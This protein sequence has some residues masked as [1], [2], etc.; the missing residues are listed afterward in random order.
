MNQGVTQQFT[1]AADST[2]LVKNDPALQVSWSA[3]SS[4]MPF[5]RRNSR[6]VSRT[7]S[8]TLPTSS[9]SSRAEIWRAVILS[10]SLPARGE[11]LTPTV[12][13]I[14][15]SSTVITGSGLGF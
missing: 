14:A 11:V 6:T 13:D 1:A 10:P 15:G 9:C 5:E 12:I 4:T 2:G 7:R 3:G 8:E